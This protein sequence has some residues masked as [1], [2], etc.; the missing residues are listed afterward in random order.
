MAKGN[1]MIWKDENEYIHV[2]CSRCGYEIPPGEDVPD[3]CPV[4]HSENMEPERRS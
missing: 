2:Y 4:C 3:V 1:W